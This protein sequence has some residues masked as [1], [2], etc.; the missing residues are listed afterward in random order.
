MH[1]VKTRFKSTILL[2]ILLILS[3]C[4]KDREEGRPTA[5]RPAAA[6]SSTAAS[7]K[8]NRTNTTSKAQ[9]P[10]GKAAKG[11]PGGAVDTPKVIYNSSYDAQFQAIFE[12]AKAGRWEEAEERATQLSENDPQDAS[13]R[14]VH[15]WVMKQRQLRRDQ[16][17]EDKI[18]EI[19]A[20]NS[21]FNP[22]LGSLLREKKDRGLPPRKDVRDAIQQLE[23]TPYI[24]PSFGKIIQQTGPMFDFETKD[25]RMSKLLSKVVSVHLDNATL[26]SIIFKIGQAEGINFVADKSLPAFKQ[27]LS[28][29]LDKV[30]LAE[31]L[32]YVSRNLEVQFQV[33]EDMIWIVDGKDPKKALEETRFYKLRKGF[34]MPAQHGASE[35]TRVATTA[36]PSTTTTETQKIQKFVNDN[37]PSAPAIQ[38]AIKDFFTGSKHMLDFERNLI[39]AKGTREQ[40]EVLEKIITEF[41]KPIQQVLIEARFIT[42]AEAA[43]LQLGATWETG[44]NFLTTGSRTP[45]DYTGLGTDV[46]VG[47]QEGFTNILS[48]KNLSATLT[49]L[50]QGGESQTLSAP[51]LTLINNLPATIRDGKVQY[52]YEE[53]TVKQQILERR[54]SSTLV[55]SGKPAKLTSGVSL[56]VLASIGGDGKTILLALN[57]EVNQEVKL[58]T[59]A[60]VTDRDDTGAVVSSFDIK[61]PES[62]T[63]SIATRVAVKSG[64]TVVMGGVLEREQRTFVESV[65]VLG[66]IP[67]IGAAFRKRTEVD[68][69]RYLLIFVTATLISESGEFIITDEDEP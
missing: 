64:Q 49:A 22:S 11:N 1:G 16:A 6:T 25:G 18:R 60:T 4:R 26:E 39:V 36:G 55:P 53:Y 34:V 41:D 51:R 23:A 69:P 46:G 32:T 63:Q 33:G 48:R 40:L 20:K 54:S 65:P 17:V 14:R 61:L 10:S 3:A 66:R 47:L 68:K 50:Q 57:P 45:T 29:N 28:V 43:F 67:I 56:D 44:K 8:G 58:V 24:P 12:A 13:I 59:F 9:R 35:V 15:T 7:D 62:R 38:A 30:K 31:F 2:S 52:Y 37:A 27:T 21:V 19:E 5:S 42:I